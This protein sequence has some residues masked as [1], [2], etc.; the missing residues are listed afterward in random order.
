MRSRAPHSSRAA[1]QW[2]QPWPVASITR[3]SA[4]VGSKSGSGGGA[5]GEELAAGRRVAL[6]RLLHPGADAA[7]ERLLLGH[8]VLLITV[9]GPGTHAPDAPPDRANDDRCPDGSRPP[10]PPLTGG[11]ST[12]MEVGRGTA[13]G[14]KIQLP[15]QPVKR[16]PSPNTLRGRPMQRLRSPF[17]IAAL[18]G[19]TALLGLLVYG[20]SHNG[21]D[22]AI[23]DSLAKGEREAA[24]D[25]D[26]PLLAGGGQ[27]DAGRLPGQGRGAERVGLLV[28]SVPDRVAA[29]GALAQAH[30]PGREGHAAGH[31]RAGQHPRRQGVHP[32]VRAD[33]PAAQGP[34]G[35]A[36]AAS[37]A[38]PACRRRS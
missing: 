33:L 11:V 15:R 18:I 10:L 24:P 4:T 14:W 23:E 25:F 17:V 27:P 19:V 12:G 22:R 32:R 8:V 9:A 31:R 5:S 1:N 16:G 21:P 20:L 6:P 36:A 28:R 2:S 30:L 3:S 26:L 13:P 38:W 29:A 35:R 34:G 37:T 7:L